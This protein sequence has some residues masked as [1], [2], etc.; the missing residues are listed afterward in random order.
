M[1]RTIR[2]TSPTTA[3][4]SGGG[5]RS[6]TRRSGPSRACWRTRWSACSGD[7]PRSSV[8]GRTDAGVHARG[9]VASFVT[10][11]GARAGAAREALNAAL[12]AR[13]RRP[14]RAPSVPAGSTRG[15]PRPRASTATGSTPRRPDPFTARFVWHRPGDLHVRA[16]ARGGPAPGGGAR[17]R[18][19]LPASGR[20][21]STVRRPR[22]ADRGARGRPVSSS[23]PGERVPATRWCGRW[24]GRW[25]RW[26]RESM[27][28]E[29]DG[30]RSCDARDRSRRRQI[31]PPH[32]LTLER[33][34]YG[35]R[36]RP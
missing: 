34:V 3:P 21:P 13:G 28:P 12:G 10:A 6:A 29:E 11:S 36:A 8:A 31:A 9:Q 4:A 23:G 1:V 5:R 32:G 25:S 24:S 16:D 20:R 19:V 26:G 30:R 14:R 33:V 22:A 17:L 35:R 15:S 7:G 18:L 27:E 2:L